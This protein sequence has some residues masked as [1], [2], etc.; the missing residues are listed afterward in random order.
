MRHLLGSLHIA[1]SNMAAKLT[2]DAV[3]NVAS[4]RTELRRTRPR[5]LT[6]DGSL[7]SFNVRNSNRTSTSPPRSAASITSVLVQICSLFV[8]PPRFLR[9][10]EEPR[11]GR[12]ARFWQEN[13]T[14]WDEALLFMKSVLDKYILFPV[15]CLSHACRWV[16]RGKKTILFTNI[17]NKRI[18]TMT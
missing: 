3:L 2:Y 16:T 6:S 13:P 14:N 4:N 7:V 18:S 15:F 9:E 1:T 10:K 12:V 5:V 17:S 11:S 8:P